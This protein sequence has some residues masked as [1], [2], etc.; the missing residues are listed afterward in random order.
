[1]AEIARGLM[2]E[3]ERLA[4]VARRTCCQEAVRR[5]RVEHEAIIDALQAH[6]ADRASRLCHEH[7][8][9][10]H[11]HLATP[12]RLALGQW[13]VPEEQRRATEAMPI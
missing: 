1:M 6:D 9:G 13:P 3:F 10:A 8:D 2:G 7:V 4:Q 5:E 11:K 12:L